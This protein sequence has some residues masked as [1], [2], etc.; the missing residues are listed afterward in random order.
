M[1][2]ISV[3]L[4]AGLLAACAADPAK[5]Q[6]VARRRSGENSGRRSARGRPPGTADDVVVEF[7]DI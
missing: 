2:L 6:D 1:R 4:M 7:R 5:I 3:F